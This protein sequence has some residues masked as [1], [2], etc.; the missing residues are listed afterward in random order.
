MEIYIV[1]ALLIVLIG[2]LLVY[3]IRLD[4]RLKLE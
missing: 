2:L 4:R 1:I 3:V